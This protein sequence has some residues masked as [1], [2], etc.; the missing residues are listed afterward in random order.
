VR[1]TID[2]PE[3]VYRQ[4]KTKAASQGRSV[5]ELILHG[6]QHELRQGEPKRPRRIKLPIVRSK[7][8]GSVPLDNTRIYEIIP[9]P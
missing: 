3:P 5:K 2:I 1:T 8:P 6:V 4:L 7:K 9:F